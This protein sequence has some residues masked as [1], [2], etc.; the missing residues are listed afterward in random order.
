[1]SST[2]AA[3]ALSVALLVL[4]AAILYTNLIGRPDTSK[5]R[6]ELD[7]AKAE[8]AVLERRVA[9]M[10]A[11]YD[12][13]VEET[14]RALAEN[15]ER[16]AALRTRL[17]ESERRVEDLRTSPVIVAAGPEVQ[18]VADSIAAE[19]RES[20][21][22]KDSEIETHVADKVVLTQRLASL[23]ELAFGQRQQIYE[24]RNGRLAAEAGWEK[25]KKGKSRA[26][27]TST[28]LALLVIALVV[29]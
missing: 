29:K 16:R 13:V 24:E 26:Q 8:I 27:L 23:E 11:A 25:E 2:K 9:D 20:I 22:D 1:M 12:S 15:A 5:E 14:N 6:A 4:A 28:A 18:A 19:Y 3:Y 10:A 17:Q 21:A 7:R